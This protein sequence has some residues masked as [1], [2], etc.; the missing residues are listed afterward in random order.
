MVH[1]Q[2][3]YINNHLQVIVQQLHCVTKVWSHGWDLNVPFYWLFL[4]NKVLIRNEDDEKCVDADENE[5][6]YGEM[7]TMKMAMIKW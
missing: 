6:E 4:K 5:D 3:D 1:Y 2:F 7:I